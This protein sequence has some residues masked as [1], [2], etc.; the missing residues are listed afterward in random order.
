MSDD[1]QALVGP[2]SLA[3]SAE[4]ISNA[5]LVSG[6][7]ISQ[8]GNLLVPGRFPDFLMPSLLHEAAHWDTF[9]TPVGQSLALGF[10]RAWRR[11]YF[12]ENH[13]SEASVDADAYETALDY[14]RFQVATEVLRPLCEGIALFTEFDLR[15]GSFSSHHHTNAI[16]GSVIWRRP[17][18]PPRGCDVSP[19]CSISYGSCTQAPT[20]SQ[21]KRKR[22]MPAL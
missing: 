17:R 21:S 3:S 22:S 8:A 9:A 6:L 13:I 16:G 19:N 20:P 15:P 4:L 18:R 12:I 14:T 10:L 5:V 2:G 1:A 11:A 7:D